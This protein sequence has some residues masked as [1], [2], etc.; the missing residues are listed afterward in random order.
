MEKEEP[1]T[2]VMQPVSRSRVN[3]IG[4]KK[5]N[6]KFLE[7]SKICIFSVQKNGENE[8]F[9]YTDYVTCSQCFVHIEKIL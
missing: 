3:S 1:G 2:G 8:R 4:K 6:F 5:N 7:Q 9:F